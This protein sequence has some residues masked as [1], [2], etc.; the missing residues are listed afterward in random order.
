MYP[1]V[2][3]V[4]MVCPRLKLFPSETR[5]TS[6]RYDFCCR[7]FS[8]QRCL[9]C[10]PVRSLF[11]TSPATMTVPWR[12]LQMLHED[13]YGALLEPGL[14]HRWSR[15]ERNSLQ[16]TKNLN[17]AVLPNILFLCLYYQSNQPT[18]QPKADPKVKQINKK[19]RAWREDGKVF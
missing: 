16:F 1:A 5:E 17:S 13:K 18:N 10:A 7:E 3:R 11:K 15:M 8:Q 2:W 4:D 12:G 6:G 19:Y 14:P 9:E